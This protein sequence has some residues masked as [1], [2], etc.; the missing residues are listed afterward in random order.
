RPITTTL[1]SSVHNRIANIMIVAAVGAFLAVCIAILYSV[2]SRA[3]SKIEDELDN[4]IKRHFSYLQ[5]LSHL[6]DLL[7]KFAVVASLIMGAR[8]D[9]VAPFLLI[10]T[11]DY[12]MQGR[13]FTLPLGTARALAVASLIGA[14]AM[15]YLENADVIWPL[16]WYFALTIWS[17]THL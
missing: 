15:F 5:N 12:L 17:V 8:P 13:F 3:A 9:W 6:S 4:Y 2:V 14:G 7:V 16:I 10:F 1:L 11:A